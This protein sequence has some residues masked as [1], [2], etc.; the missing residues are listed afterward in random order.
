M[1]H[2]FTLP[3]KNSA[4]IQSNKSSMQNVKVEHANRFPV[5]NT[6]KKVGKLIQKIINYI[7]YGL[8]FICCQYPRNDRQLYVGYAISSAT[9]LISRKLLNIKIFFT[10]D[11]KFILWFNYE[12]YLLT[13]WRHQ[14]WRHFPWRH[15]MLNGHD[16][17]LGIWCIDFD[18]YH[19]FVDDTKESILLLR[20]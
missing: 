13:K 11:G 20:V 1:V 14:K 12:I 2:S 10:K 16:F 17:S 7:K 19:I 15:S 9:R 5:V 3:N 4:T 6:S 18:F 8:S